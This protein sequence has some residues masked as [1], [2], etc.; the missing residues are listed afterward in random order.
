MS[1]DKLDS[2]YK[3]AFGWP[4]SKLDAV[5]LAVGCYLC[6]RWPGNPSPAWGV[7]LGSQS[8][9]KSTILSMFNDYPY[10]LETDDLTARGLTS[11]YVDEDNP[12][13]DHSFFAQLSC[14][15]D[16]VGVKV[17]LI[18]ELSS[19]TS[20]DPMKLEAI[21]GALRAAHVGKHTSHGG[22]GGTKM[23]DIGSFGMLIGTTE[24]F[25]LLRTKL[26]TFGDRFLTIRM[27]PTRDT[28]AT[29]MQDAKDAWTVDPVKKDSLLRAIKKETHEL[30]NRG[31]ATLDN[32]GTLTDCKRSPIQLSKLQGWA[33]I[34][35]T[36]ATS[37]ISSTIM[38]DAPGRCFRIVDQ[39]KSWGNMHCL[40]NGRRAWAD[41][42]MRIC[43]RVFQDSMANANFLALKELWPDP[44]PIN[45]QYMD[46]YMQW[47]K[48]DAVRMDNGQSVHYGAKGKICLT[49]GFHSLLSKSGYFD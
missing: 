15:R 7:I 1:M 46:L 23:R 31:I 30:L 32:I 37:P 4:Q 20:G 35:S 22:I 47:S 38:V 16:P 48:F 44:V 14:K 39:V 10:S 19:L 40:L 8:C 43:R 24:M 9:G 17:W 45:H 21:L 18:Q 49:P 25:E 42:E 2:L 12:E 29:I 11:C 34:H 5:H 33:A 26:S 41:D 13:K 6:P 27:N 3:Q 28:L 36:F